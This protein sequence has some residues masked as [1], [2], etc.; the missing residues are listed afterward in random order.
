MN[1]NGP[2]R[3]I[4]ATGETCNVFR[5]A[6]SIVGGG[7]RIEYRPHLAGVRCRFSAPGGAESIDVGGLRAFA[8]AAVYV[9]GEHDI[10]P[11]DH[12][13]YTLETWN[14]EGVQRFGSRDEPVYQ[15]LDCRRVEGVHTWPA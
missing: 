15:R 1:R 2:S 6:S 8:T 13:S 7:E 11:S 4:R 12:I 9:E 10:Q 5:P 14:V 3:M